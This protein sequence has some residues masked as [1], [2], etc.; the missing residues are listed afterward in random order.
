MEGVINPTEAFDFSNIIL[1]HPV[2]IQGGACFTKI[3]H[4]NKPLYIHTTKCQTRQGIVKTGKNR[5]WFILML[6]QVL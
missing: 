4:K 1:A 3:E 5:K 2:G 6:K